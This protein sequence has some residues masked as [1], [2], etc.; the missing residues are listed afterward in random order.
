MSKRQII[1]LLGLLIILLPFLGFNSRWDTVISVIVGI[2][3]IYLASSIQPQN[4]SKKDS[5]N[6]SQSFSNSTDTQESQ[7][8]PFVDH[9]TDIKTDSQSVAN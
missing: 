7:D 2:L 9:R 4:L 3:I 8:L 1:I 5:I 6:K